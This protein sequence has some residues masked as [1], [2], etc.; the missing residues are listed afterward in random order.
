MRRALERA[1]EAA[2]EA[3][4]AQRRYAQAV[5]HECVYDTGVSGGVRLWG[6]QWRLPERYE[7]AWAILAW[8]TAHGPIGDLPARNELARYYRDQLSHWGRFTNGLYPGGP[9][10]S[11]DEADED[12]ENDVGPHTPT[13]MDHYLADTRGH[14]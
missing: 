2:R 12:W 7:S 11:E 14:Y 1:E 10:W 9:H 6:P 8:M 5:S 3:R 13:L 4:D